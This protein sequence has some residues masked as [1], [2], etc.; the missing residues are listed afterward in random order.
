MRAVPLG[1]AVLAL[2]AA[3]SLARAQQLA[4]RLQLRLD[5]SEAEAVL[6][7]VAKARAHETIDSSDW[8][9][10]Q[11][12]EPYQRL[13]RR[14][15]S[16]HRDF[17]DAD[18]QRFV[19][20]DSLGA[21]AAALRQTL[22][23]WKRADLSAAADRA[24]AYL[25]ADARIRATVYPV[26]KPQTNSFVYETRTDPAIFLYLDPTKT[27]AQVENIVAHELHHIGYSTVSARGDSAIASLPPDVK[28]AADWVGAFGEGFAMLAAAGGPDVHPHASSSPQDRERW[29]RDMANFSRDLGAVERFLLDVVQGRLKNE[30]ER[31]R[32]AYSFFGVQ[33]PW[34][35]VGWKMAVT[36]ERRYGRARLIECM[37]DPRTV[38]AWY[39]RA[40]EAQI[41]TGGEQLPLW[42]PELL[43]ALGVA[44]G[45]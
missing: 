15:A 5:P 42:S 32:V 34:Y 13:K 21:R 1:A 8:S 12:T 16:L 30:E 9:R 44:E 31:N 11:A 2:A 43:R 22:D 14:E 23:V 10:L 3:A 20:S 36:I 37:L 19:L 29:D 28:A 38:L 40:A 41:A 24:F 18:F 39:N 4:D 6:A 26:I 25:P 33:G 27:A 7:I 35:T 45:G 17:T